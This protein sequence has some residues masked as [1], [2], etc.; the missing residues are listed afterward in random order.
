MAGKLG[1]LVIEI[2]ATTAKL[3]QSMTASERIVKKSTRAMSKAAKAARKS[4]NAIGIGAGVGTVALAAMVKQTKENVDA[5]AKFADVIGLTTE[6]L[7]GYQLAAKITG[8]EIGQLN[9]G[10]TRLQKKYCGCRGGPSNT[11]PGI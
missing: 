6:Q 10:L 4:I 5:T 2:V 3:R 11:N 1:A 9:T 7:T 8:S